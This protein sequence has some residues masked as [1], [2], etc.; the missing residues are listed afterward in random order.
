[1]THFLRCFWVVAFLSLLSATGFSCRSDHHE[2]TNQASYQQDQ[3]K[4]SKQKRNR[5]YQRSQTSASTQSDVLQHGEVPAKV[6]KVLLH[7]RQNGRAPDGY[8]GSRNFGN[9]EKHLPQQDEQG[10]RIRY[11]EWDVNPKIQG[12]NRGPE[13]LITGSDNRAYFTRDHYNS[14]IEIK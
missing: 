4:H 6:R 9:Y 3:R 2:Q 14:F 1:M 10:N 12:K 13:R 11:Q 7:I 8:V 5:P